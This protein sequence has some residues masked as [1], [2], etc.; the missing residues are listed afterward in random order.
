MPGLLFANDRR[1]AW[2][3]GYYAATAT[4][5]PP[6][7]PA[8]GAISCDVAVVGGGYTGLSAALHLAQ[9]GADVR[10]LE[11][12]RVG[13][14]ASGRNGGQLGSGQRVDQPTLEARLGRAAARAL[15]AMGE[16]A[17]ALVHD[18][19][20]AHAEVPA[21]MPYLHLP[22]QS[23]SDRIL[24]AMNRKHTGDA[25]R[26][27]IEKVRDARPDIALS[28][29]FI[30]GFPGE[31][32]ADFE[33]TMRIVADIGFAS[34]FSFKYS[35]RPGTPAADDTA[36]IAEAVK[37]E[38]LARLQALLEEQRQ[39]F[40]RGTVGKVVEVLLE[41]PG[42]HPGQL[43]GKSPYLQAVHL[44]GAGLGIGDIVSVRIIDQSSNSLQ[45]EALRSPVA[46][47]N[48]VADKAAADVA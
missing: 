2:P 17:K 39:A 24:K 48:G 5:P 3:Q 23:G 16:D 11:A 41:K 1:G 45:G 30:V 43:G 40:N 44:D 9:A 35:T 33:E 13:F 36:Q 4:P 22:V 32:D 42:R 8:T 21:L 27:I 29:D 10:L 28:S 14:G 6:F 12:H 19:I 18:L 37:A 47:T 31:S 38:R 20:A 15:W 25:Y 46:M 26:R 7:A 34:A